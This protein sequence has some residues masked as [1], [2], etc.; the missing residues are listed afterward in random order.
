VSN[1]VGKINKA[2]DGVQIMD[3]ETVGNGQLEQNSNFAA[4]K[5]KLVADASGDKSSSDINAAK[6]EELVR[7]KHDTNGS[8]SPVKRKQVSGESDSESE[9]EDRASPSKKP[10]SET[11][12][13]LTDEED[14]DSPTKMSDED[15]DS[16]VNT[17]PKKRKRMTFS[18]YADVDENELGRMYDATFSFHVFLK[19]AQL[20]EHF[21]CISFYPRNAVLEQY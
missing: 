18:G 14:V 3:V 7:E 2:D 4:V 21:G 10:R 6:A 5:K 1:D 15:I 12:K 8:S 11:S 20:F 16:S 9:G 17:G 13:R 19:D